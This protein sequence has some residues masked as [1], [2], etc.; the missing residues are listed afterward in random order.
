MNDIVLPGLYRHF[1]GNLYR[2]IGDIMDTETDTYKVLYQNEQG[3][4]YVRSYESW[5][6]IA[7]DTYGNPVER[8][9]RV[10]N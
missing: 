9:R 4:Y 6:D 10:G 7:Y 5:L 1:K 8:F 2:V 3:S